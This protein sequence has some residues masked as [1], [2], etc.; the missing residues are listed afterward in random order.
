M[1][2]FSLC[3]GS[4]AGG[5]SRYI[6]AGFVYKYLGSNFPFGTL[7]VNLSGCFLIGF[8]NVLAVEKFLL[9]PNTRV[10]LIA[11]FCGAFTT[12]STLILETV[13]LFK[14]GELMKSLLNGV[15]SL[16]L[17]ITLFY[18]GQITAKML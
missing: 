7:V 4:L 13:N 5:V 12:F 3:V 16:L 6:L 9:N 2:W 11:G 17:G 15:G 1:K 14:D 18:L 10:L 8:L